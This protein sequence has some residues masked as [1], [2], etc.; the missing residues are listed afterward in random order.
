MENRL[1]FLCGEQKKN[2][3]HRK[4]AQKINIEATTVY[5]LMKQEREIKAS[6]LD[7]LCKYFD[8]TSDFLLCN[9][10]S[11]YVVYAKGTD[12]K[13]ILTYDEAVKMKDIIT[14]SEVPIPDVKENEYPKV[15]VKRVIDI[16]P[17]VEKMLAMQDVHD[18]LKNM[19]YI[20]IKDLVDLI[21]KYIL[22]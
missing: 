17:L 13:I 5:R 14:I 12:R 2:L 15:K 7:Q 8:V 16:N 4:L 22:K 18:R 6:Y 3:S 10:N 21:D 9:S 20:Q 1:S 19:D 11:G